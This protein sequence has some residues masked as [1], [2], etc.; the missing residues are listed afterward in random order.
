LQGM[1]GM[2]LRQKRT[3]WAVAVP[4]AT[5]EKGQPKCSGCGRVCKRIADGSYACPSCEE[6][7][8]ME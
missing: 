6:L 7:E 2:T 1:Q 3:A 5:K 4:E 8:F